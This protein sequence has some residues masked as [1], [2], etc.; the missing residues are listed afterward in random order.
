MKK[1]LVETK[2]YK[3]PLLPLPENKMTLL[4]DKKRKSDYFLEYNTISR[5]FY[6]K[7]FVQLIFL[8]D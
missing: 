2:V 4:I 6:R 3:K 1:D 7:V 5:E 8:I